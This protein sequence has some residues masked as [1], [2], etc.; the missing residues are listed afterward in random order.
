MDAWNRV[1]TILG[2]YNT[3]KYETWNY[4]TRHART[5]SRDYRRPG[6]ERHSPTKD[7]WDR[8]KLRHVR[9]LG[10]MKLQNT[11]YKKCLQRLGQT[12][13]LANEGWLKLGETMTRGNYNTCNYDTWNYNTR[14]MQEL[15]PEI[16]IDRVQTDT[17]T[18]QGRL[19]SSHETTTCAVKS[20]DHEASLTGHIT[21]GYCGNYTYI[22][23]PQ[24]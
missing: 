22:Y 9:K 7:D 8:V 21:T 2:N 15:P 13:A 12:Y 4:D 1:I 19:I 18:H 17:P 16:V 14:H 10:H 24:T 5:T 6:R 3:C 11:R 20:T 23:R